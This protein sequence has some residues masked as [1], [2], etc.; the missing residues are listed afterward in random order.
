MSIRKNI[1]ANYLGQGWTAVM[2]LAFVPIYVA[3]LGMEAYG[4]IGVFASLHAWLTILDMGFS[5]TINR[6]MARFQAG[7]NSAQGIRNLLRSLEVIYAVVA[8]IVILG[9]GAAASWFAETWLNVEKL[10]PTTVTDALV[11]TGF[12]IASRMVEGLYKGALQGLQ[13]QVWLNGVNAILSSIRWGGA[14][15]VLALITP[16]IEAFFQWQM[17]AS[18]LAIFVFALKV[19]RSLPSIAG[20]AAFRLESLQPVWRFSSGMAGIAFLKLFLT[21]IDKVLLTRMLSLENFGIYTLATVVG[22]AFSQMISPLASAMF[23]RLTELIERK[24]T[25]ALRTTYHRACQLMSVLII[26]PALTFIMYAKP[27]LGL[28]MQDRAIATAV[29]PIAIPLVIGMIFNS[30]MNI[31][32][33]LQLA[34]GW[35]SLAMKINLFAAAFVVPALVVAINRYGALGAAYVWVMLNVGYFLIGIH[36]MHR[37]LLP[38]DKWR[39][40]FEDIG[41]PLSAA[42]MLGSLLWSLAPS[43]GSNWHVVVYLSGTCCLLWLVVGLSA[44]ELR[45][46]FLGWFGIDR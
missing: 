10:P 36:F 11:I 16:T 45:R 3:Y 40:Y 14:A 24:K 33:M 46:D 15:L 7:G 27:A 37:R 2:G 9:V 5:P 42:L 22:S 12:V 6:E 41:V 13:L 23:P 31:P 43:M 18:L 44:K 17:A 35:T 20:H 1:L 21:Q 8:T 38:E 34:H 32:Y 4:L 19:Y 29:A 30:F 26:P 39:W 25:D 28:W